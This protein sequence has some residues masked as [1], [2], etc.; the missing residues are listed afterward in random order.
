MSKK[1]KDISEA[2]KEE[3]A[4]AAGA[5]ETGVVLA[6]EVLPTSLPIMPIR[7]RP[8]F[9]GIHIPLAVREN[10]LSVVEWALGSTASR[11]I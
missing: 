2:V 5:D 6:G 11:P 4:K 1:K 7:P 8:L 10:Q 3:S 9:P